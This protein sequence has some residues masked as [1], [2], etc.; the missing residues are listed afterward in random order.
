MSTLTNGITVVK[1]YDER[2]KVDQQTK[3]REL[4]LLPISNA[5]IY[6]AQPFSNVR[7]RRKR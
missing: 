5:I 3:A 6:P 2:L 7:K 1:E 4:N